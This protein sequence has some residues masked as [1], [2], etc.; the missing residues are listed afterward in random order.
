MYHV[1]SCVIGEDRR[2]LRTAAALVGLVVKISSR[3]WLDLRLC[4][5]F[6]AERGFLKNMIIYPKPLTLL[7]SGTKALKVFTLTWHGF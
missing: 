4:M 6:E 3:L 1:C 2:P 5:C 7:Y